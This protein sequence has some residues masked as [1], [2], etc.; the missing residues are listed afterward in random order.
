MLQSDAP[1]H[2]VAEH[3]KEPDAKGGRTCGAINPSGGV[4]RMLAVKPAE[5][6]AEKCSGRSR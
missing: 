1:I 5:Q 6:R 2:Q 3:G 4:P